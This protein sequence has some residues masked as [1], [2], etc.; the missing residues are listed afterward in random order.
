MGKTSEIT[1]ESKKEKRSRKKKK[2]NTQFT[3]VLKFFNIVVG[4][5]VI[6]FGVFCY[7]GGNQ[8]DK[9]TKNTVDFVNL[10]MP[11]YIALSGLIILSV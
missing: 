7:I 1:T 9:K 8:E 10:I 3:T 6:G 5:A 4:I 2:D 11:G